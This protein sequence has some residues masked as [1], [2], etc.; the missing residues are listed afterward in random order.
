MHPIFK[1]ERIDFVN[2]IAWPQSRYGMVYDFTGEASGG[3][4]SAP[5]IRGTDGFC[6]GHCQRAAE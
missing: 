6:M 1:L 2:E 4:I 3:Q 5:M